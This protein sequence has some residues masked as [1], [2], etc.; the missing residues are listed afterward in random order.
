MMYYPTVGKQ[1]YLCH[2][3]TQSHR[4]H[5]LAFQKRMVVNPPKTAKPLEPKKPTQPRQPKMPWSS[6]NHQES[7]TWVLTAKKTSSKKLL[8]IADS[9]LKVKLCSLILWTSSIYISYQ[10]R[11]I[12]LSVYIFKLS[13]VNAC[14]CHVGLKNSAETSELPFLRKFPNSPMPRQS[15]FG[16]V[17]PVSESIENK[18]Y[19]HMALFFGIINDGLPIKPVNIVFFWQMEEDPQNAFF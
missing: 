17:H 19:H 16:S 14:Q 4:T 13:K 6:T 8:D 18:A 12:S 11:K 7:K 10:Q 2:I 1:P 15:M 9:Q 5:P 3:P